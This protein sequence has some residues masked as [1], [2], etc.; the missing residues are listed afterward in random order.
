MREFAETALPIIVI[1]GLYAEYIAKHY[2]EVKNNTPIPPGRVEFGFAS[3]L[4]VLLFIVG[5]TEA[6]IGS[7]SG[8]GWEF[9]NGLL[10]MALALLAVVPLNDGEVSFGLISKPIANVFMNHERTLKPACECGLAVGY[11][12]FLLDMVLRVTKVFT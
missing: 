1:L 2:N 7:Q 10:M 5:G 8:Y 6:F 9:W 4:L 11:A 3:V 12:A